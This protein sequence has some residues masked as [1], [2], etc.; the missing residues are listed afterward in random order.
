MPIKATQRGF[1]AGGVLGYLVVHPLVMVTARFMSSPRGPLEDLWQNLVIEGIRVSY[2]MEMLPWGIAFALLCAVVGFMVVRKGEAQTQGE[3][4]KGVM[5]LAGAACHEL[6]QPMQVVMGY[7]QLLTEDV[8]PEE[9]LRE[10]LE[11]IIAEIDR[12]SLVLRKIQSITRYE[13]LDYID[14]VKIIDIE[15]AS[16]RPWESKG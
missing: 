1:I 2:S 3:R 4:L 15:K 6:N 12:M 9:P 16:R 5:E 10:H 8:A 11:K 7:A 14:G 13:T